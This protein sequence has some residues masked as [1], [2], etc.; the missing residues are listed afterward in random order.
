MN[1]S[2]Q[3][4]PFH[5]RLNIFPISTHTNSNSGPLIFLFALSSHIGFTGSFWIYPIFTTVYICFRHRGSTLQYEEMVDTPTLIAA[6]TPVKTGAG[7][8]AST[9]QADV[10]HQIP[11][12]FCLFTF[13]R[14]CRGGLWRMNRRRNT[15]LI[16]LLA[17][18]S[19]SFPD[20]T[21]FRRFLVAVVFST[22][23]PLG[24]IQLAFCM[25]LNISCSLAGF[26]CSLFIFLS[27]LVYL[28]S[29]GA[30]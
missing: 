5:F 26:L 10:L 30:L 11:T 12:T 18:H 6:W 24:F 9:R 2:L 15:W 20:L 4:E 29:A 14:F 21:F 16:K 19:L 25:G 13:S 27:M 28:P 17:F 23:L 3:S 7:T 22:S 1:S 8:I